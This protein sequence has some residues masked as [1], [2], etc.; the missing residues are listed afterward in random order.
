MFGK[1]VVS[2]VILAAG[3]LVPMASTASANTQGFG[4]C[5]DYAVAEHDIEPWL[6]HDACGADTFRECYWILRKEY[7]PAM[8]A[9]TACR[10]ADS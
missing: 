8:I 5:M 2:A 10:I 1:A 6:A 4:D 7:V 9:V 3:A